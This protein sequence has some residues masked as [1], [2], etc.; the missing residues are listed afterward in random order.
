VSGSIVNLAGNIDASV[1]VSVGGNRGKIVINAANLTIADGSRP[2]DPVDNTL[3]EQWI[4]S[5][6]AANTDLE[7]VAH[8]STNGTIT[9]NN[10]SDGFLALGSG[11]LASHG[12]N[13]GGI[14]F[15]S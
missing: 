1:P 6:S 13:T 14:T 12:H 3:Y 7:L 10:I 15:V 9:V 2:A 4:E 5:Q 11:D 8:S